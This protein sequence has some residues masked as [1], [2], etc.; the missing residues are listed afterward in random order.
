MLILAIQA[1]QRVYLKGRC[2]GGSQGKKN[3]C[4]KLKFQQPDFSN[5]LS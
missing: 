5:F 4:W 1:I 3:G 2:Q